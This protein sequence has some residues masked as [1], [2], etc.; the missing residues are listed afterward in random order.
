M[1]NNHLKIPDLLKIFGFLCAPLLAIWGLGEGLAVVVPHM[2]ID[3]PL[4]IASLI[5]FIAFTA[6][7]IL[8]PARYLLRSKLGI[9][10]DSNP[11]RLRLIDLAP[12]KRTPRGVLS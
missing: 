12:K 2:G 4:Q 5:A 7:I 8:V 1:D 6:A 3:T 9:F 10:N 11:D